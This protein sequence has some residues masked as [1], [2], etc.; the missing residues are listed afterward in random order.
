MEDGRGSAQWVKWGGHIGTWK[1]EGSFGA[2][3]DYFD[4]KWLDPDQL[5]TFTATGDGFW[6]KSM[7]NVFDR[8]VVMA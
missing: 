5:L 4:M 2:L 1:W 3:G 8:F 7:F 6:E